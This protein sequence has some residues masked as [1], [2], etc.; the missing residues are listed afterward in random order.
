MITEADKLEQI[1]WHT[2]QLSR[3]LKTISSMVDSLHDP[4]DYINLFPE[5]D[6]LISKLED[7]TACAKEGIK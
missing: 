2:A 3:I 4:L 1:R 5:F 7:S 6:R